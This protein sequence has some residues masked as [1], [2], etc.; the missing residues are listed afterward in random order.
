MPMRRVPLVVVALLA[1][2]VVVGVAAQVGAVVP[3]VPKRATALGAPWLVAAFAVGALLRRPVVA[4]AGGAVVLSVGTLTYYLVRVAMTGHARA[5]T[6]AV[7]ALGWAVAA[8]V[9]GGAMGALGAAWRKAARPPALAAAVPTAALTGEAILLAGEWRS[10]TS[11]GVLV[12]ELALAAAI[13][14]VCARRRAPLPAAALA[15]LVLAVAFAAGEAE[16]RS[17]MRAVGWQGV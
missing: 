1:A 8:A 11:M 2:A 12:V 5:L 6:I 17:A 10:R 4:A 15:A 9:A 13:L 16:L 3:G 14:P 7:I